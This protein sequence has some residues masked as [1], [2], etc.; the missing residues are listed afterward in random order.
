[1]LE[2]LQTHYLLRLLHVC[3]WPCVVLL[4][5]G[6]SCGQDRLWAAQ[7]KCTEGAWVTAWGWVCALEGGAVVFARC[8]GRAGA[9]WYGLRPIALKPAWSCLCH[10]SMGLAGCVPS[11]VGVAASERRDGCVWLQ[12]NILPGTKGAVRRLLVHA[13][14][15]SCGMLGV[16]RLRLWL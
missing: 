1:L 16:V 11:V 14:T 7:V 10:N 3:V 8:L 5:F 13:N 4:S 6:V 9:W 12:R 15:A 2:G